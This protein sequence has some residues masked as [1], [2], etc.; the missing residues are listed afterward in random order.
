MDVIFRVPGKVEVEDVAD[1]RNVETAGSDI[2]RSQQRDLAG[3]ELVE[4]VHAA[5]LVHVAVQRAGV[6]AVLDERLVQHGYVAL[7]IAEDDAV[8]DV[9]AA[10]ERTQQFA[11]RPVLGGGA[12]T[13][14]L[15]DGLG[16]GGGLGHLDANGVFEELL[17]K[18]RDLGRHGGREE[19]RLPT[20]RQK[21]ADL[22][23]VGNE[24]HVEHAVGLVDDE[25]LHTHE[26][27]ASALEMVE[28]PARRSYQD[29]DAAVEFLDLVV[30]RDAAD[31]KRDVELVVGAI[32][33]ERLS[34][35][36]GQFARRC[37][38]Q[39]SRHASPGAA[40]LEACD[41]R[42]GEGGRLAGARLGDAQHVLAGQRDGDGLGLDGGRGRV[43]GRFDSGQNLGAEAKLSKRFRFQK[44]VTPDASLIHACV[45]SP[46]EGGASARGR[47]RRRG[48]LVPVI[49]LKAGQ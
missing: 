42:Q 47:T 11:L 8:L 2:T 37:Q 18:T 21:F 43:A 12:E 35:L 24:A 13:E 10:D 17:H 40:R 22:L 28:Q 9:L 38:D 27:Q 19:Q 15:G 14:P 44:S 45:T 34:D 26:H 30:H 20:R 29:I 31:Q 23:D 1:F 4:R 25:D 3:T 48:S 36:S 33:L 41:H 32:L 16:G 5:L 49:R 7:A 39:G 46:A 6:E